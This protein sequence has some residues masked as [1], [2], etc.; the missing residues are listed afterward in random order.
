MPINSRA[1]RKSIQELGKKFIPFELTWITDTFGI[2]QGIKG[3]F[4]KTGKIGCDIEDSYVCCLDYGDMI[5][6][7]IVDVVSRFATRNL[8]VNFERA[9]LRWFWETGRIE[10]YDVATKAWKYIKQGEQ[11][12]AEGYNENISEDMY[13]DEIRAFLAGA[14]NPSA[15][16]N[17]IEK[18]IAVLQLLSELE[19]SDGGFERK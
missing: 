19:D 2:P 14:E 1:F 5:G 10:I 11:R 8:I 4:R 15:Y 16:P 3:Y 6:T 17:N 18:D 13:V 9:Q 12:H 7:M